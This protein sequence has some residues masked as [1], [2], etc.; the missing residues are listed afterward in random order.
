M[1]HNGYYTVKISE[2]DTEQMKTIKGGKSVP[3]KSKETLNVKI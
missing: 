3:E 1:F 2:P